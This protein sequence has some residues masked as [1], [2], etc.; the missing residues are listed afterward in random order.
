MGFFFKEK[1]FSKNFVCVIV[2]M[3]AEN[4]KV[5]LQSRIYILTFRRPNI[6]FPVKNTLPLLCFTLTGV[7]LD[8]PFL[9]HV[10]QIDYNRS[11]TIC[12]VL[13]ISRNY[14]LI[15]YWIFAMII[16]CDLKIRRF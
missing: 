8:I 7:Y 10:S 12:I 3:V 16:N 9:E 2:H 13:I 6:F 1:T 5:K 15:V 14:D 11:I 4:V